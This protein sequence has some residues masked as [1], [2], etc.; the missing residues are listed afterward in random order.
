M[1]VQKIPIYQFLEGSGKSFVIPVYQRD[2]AWTTANCNKLWQDLLH[3][4][5]TDKLTHF[6]GTI[7]SINS[8]FQ[9]YLIVDGQQRLTTTS[10]L[11]LAL[12][13]YLKQ[14]GEKNEQENILTEQTLDFLINK[15]SLDESKR[16]RLK[17]NQQD[18]VDFDDLFNIEKSKQ[19]DSNITLNYDFFYRKI[20]SK[21][22]TPVNL[23][24]LFQKLEIVLINL[25]RGVDD[26][27]LI[28][29][30]LNSTGVDLTDADLV[31]NFILMDLEPEY[32][33]IIYEKYWLKLEKLVDDIAKFIRVFLMYK[34]QESVKE[35]SRDVYNKFREYSER[36]F[37]NDKEK[38]LK[39]LLYFAEI[40]GYFVNKNHEDKD[41]NL[42]LTRLYNLE[43]TV[44]Y[45]FLMDLFYSFRNHI[46][47]KN[48]VVKSINL[49]ESYA[50][51]KILVDNTTQ[52]LNKLFLVLAKDIK[53][54]VDWQSKYFDILSFIL[55][56]KGASQKF[57]TDDSFIEALTQKEVYKL[58]SKN[59]DFLIENLE[60]FNSSYQIKLDDLTVEHIMPQNLKPEEKSK[61]GPNWQE[62]HKKYVHTLGNLRLT[63]KN[64]EMG[65][66][67]FEEKQKIDE[68]A[69]KLSLNEGLDNV[70]NWGEVEIVNRGNK[71]ATKAVNIWSYPATNF[72]K[73][74][75]EREIYD[76]DEELDFSGKK[77]KCLY[78]QKEIIEIKYWRDVLKIAC[79]KLY[80]TSPTEFNHII[81]NSELTKY[82][83]IETENNLRSAV[84]FNNNKFVDGNQSANSIIRFISK[85]CELL[86]F[87]KNDIKIEF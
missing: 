57:P 81:Q 44:C 30:S 17:P 43:F 8:N 80:L 45:S 31:R 3:L 6:L 39:E 2:Y 29:E 49:I 20:S 14:K 74:T 60:N 40:Y 76:I 75:P 1:Q 7:V 11:L 53:K 87:D 12:H 25:D 55:L 66:K 42:A 59:R 67:S 64:S 72:S 86:N 70:S 4:N 32:Q 79:D 56:N 84:P 82:F 16:I 26:P 68:E 83:S 47:D 65:N 37:T 36:T 58:R 41:I 24:V 63:A 18:K 48:T 23:F 71:L 69:K 35:T 9:E 73:S 85:L 27:Q 61:L 78:F 54:E 28:F 5:E 62:I 22:I 38:L 19:I 77:P 51:R 13:N 15:H 34:L 52:G 21:E 46:L 10:I 33:E 50:F